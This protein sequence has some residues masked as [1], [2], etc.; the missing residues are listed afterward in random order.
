MTDEEIVECPGCVVPA[1][2]IE[3]KDASGNWRVI[4]DITNGTP[5]GVRGFPYVVPPFLPTDM[6]GTWTAPDGSTGP[7]SYPK[8][9]P[10]ANGAMVD[11]NMLYSTFKGKCKCV[12]GD[13]I[14]GTHGCGVELNIILQNG[15]GQ[16]VQGCSPDSAGL[17]PAV[18]T[19][20]GT[21]TST[22]INLCVAPISS[23]GGSPIISQTDIEI[24]VTL[25]CTSCGTENGPNGETPIPGC[26]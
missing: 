19:N 17:L 9:V 5:L 20:C 13:C 12:S 4:E 22:I 7:L 18:L 26:C 1:L 25:T 11:N 10:G 3:Y 14:Q 24:K 23:G 8:K 15:M 21:S 6:S 16:Y 2:K